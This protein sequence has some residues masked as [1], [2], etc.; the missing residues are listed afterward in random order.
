MR[1]DLSLSQRPELQ[2]KLSPQ[3]IQRIEI[4]QLPAQ[5]LLE[6]I[7]NEVAENE[8]LEVEAPRADLAPVTPTLE[9][10]GAA[11][12]ELDEQVS[13]QLETYTSYN[14]V[15]KPRV[16]KNDGETDPKL[17]AM[18]NAPDAPPSLGDH[19]R[20]QLAF[21]SLPPHV[22]DFVDILID[23]LDENGFLAVPLEDIR[24][25][26][27]DTISRSDAEQALEFLKS[28]DPI[29]VGARDMR[30]CFLMQL[31]PDL[32]HYELHR[33]LISDHLDDWRDNKL[34]RIVRALAIDLDTL[35]EVMEEL[36]HLL[37]PPPGRL[38]RTEVVVPVR[39][40]V[41]VKKNEGRYEVELE[42]DYYP[43][44]SVSSSYVDAVRDRGLDARYRRDIKGK[45][46]RARF[47]IEAIEQRRNTLRRVAGEIVKHQREFFENDRLMPL[48][49]RDVADELGLHV[50]TV[51]R[52]ISDKWMQ[53]QKGIF[54]MKHFFT[55][56][57][58]GG[59]A[60]GLESRDS[61]RIKVKEIIDA[62]D[63]D[64]PLSDEDI[65][66]KL[67]SLGL[68]IARRT[69]TKYRKM[70]NIPSSRERR[71]Y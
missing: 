22:H 67:K 15:L 54:P 56:A 46:D 4:L 43:H 39:P 14:E 6:L 48:K 58:P 57:A 40:D 24:I 65:V 20:E 55:G 11:D 68:D 63:K 19:L 41:V 3:L 35:K 17:A 60:E 2:L 21:A 9:Q 44:L 59:E 53:T 12:K 42:D 18:A 36:R 62:E 69:V 49:M 25:P 61:V 27:D 34:P 1:L 16:R 30:E 32:E 33:R 31:D 45:L 26:Y 50:S 10:G 52:A 71:E 7:Q 70:M 29:G 64:N 47:L 38:F 28:L 23:Q 8:T 66:D 51:S 5:E 37:K 13:D